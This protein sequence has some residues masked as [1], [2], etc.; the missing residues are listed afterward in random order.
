M[1]LYAG[2]IN[3]KMPGIIINDDTSWHANVKEGKF[4][5]NHPEMKSYRLCRE[6]ELVFSRDKLLERLHD[7]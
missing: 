4:T 2:S 1:V 6:G 7:P 5:I 3:M